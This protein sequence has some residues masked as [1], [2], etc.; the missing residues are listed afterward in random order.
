MTSFASSLVEESATIQLN[1]VLLLWKKVMRIPAYQHLFL[2]AAESA[3]DMLCASSTLR[4]RFLEHLQLAIFEETSP[5]AM[6]ELLVTTDAVLLENTNS[7]IYP[8]LQSLFEWLFVADHALSQFA[9]DNQDFLSEPLSSISAVRDVLERHPKTRKPYSP[10]EASEKHR[11]LCERCSEALQRQ[12]L[13]KLTNRLF[14]QLS[15]VAKAFDARPVMKRIR[16]EAAQLLHTFLNTS[17]NGSW[18]VQ[19]DLD[20]LTDVIRQLAGG[21]IQ[22]QVK[23]TSAQNEKGIHVDL[24]D[25]SIQVIDIVP[26]R[27][28]ISQETSISFVGGEK[29]PKSV[30]VLFEGICI[31]AV[32]TAFAYSRNGSPSETGN[33]DLQLVL[34]VQVSFKIDQAAFSLVYTSS[35]VSITSCNASFKGT[36]KDALYRFAFPFARG[37]IIASVEEKVQNLMDNKI[38]SLFRFWNKIRQDVQT[39]WDAVPRKVSQPRNDY[40]DDNTAPTTPV[41]TLPSFQSQREMFRSGLVDNKLHTDVSALEHPVDDADSI[42]A[43][44]PDISLGSSWHASAEYRRDSIGI[45]KQQIIDSPSSSS[46]PYHHQSHHVHYQEHS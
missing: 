17:S 46:P 26:K 24:G 40:T 15:S 35:H 1:L 9:L 21:L 22:I 30:S 16:Q 19:I 23:G 41:P 36:G 5:V 4:H 18:Q 11:N 3:V 38:N 25:L 37:F 27:I 13:V 29:R 8:I 6:Q 33:A 39:P 14:S 20:S 12:P 28:N 2:E 44:S 10:S 31:N 32:D 45:L 34:N 43:S 42:H 7:G